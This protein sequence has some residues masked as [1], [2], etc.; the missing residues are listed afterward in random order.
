MGGPDEGAGIPPVVVSSPKVGPVSF[1]G[2]ISVSQAEPVQ[3][4]QVPLSGAE[5]PGLFGGE[6][7][8]RH[9]EKNLGAPHQWILIG[10][11]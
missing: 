10:S 9:H 3:V 6:H 7:G 1:K 2:G 11:R 5:V 4:R 8:N